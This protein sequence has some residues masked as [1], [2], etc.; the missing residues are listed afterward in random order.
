MGGSVRDATI[1]SVGEVRLL[2]IR[3]EE[4]LSLSS[5]GQEGDEPEHIRFCRWCFCLLLDHSI[6]IEMYLMIL[7]HL[8]PYNISDLKQLSFASLG[9]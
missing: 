5:S 3:A 9:T 6:C 7:F 2:V 1:E 4:F 8:F